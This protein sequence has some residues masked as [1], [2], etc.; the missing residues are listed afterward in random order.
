MVESDSKL[1]VSFLKHGLE[2]YDR[3]IYPILSRV[4]EFVRTF[5]S[6]SWSWVPKSAN[7][8]VDFVA[9]HQLSGMD[10]AVWV[11]RPPSSLVRILNKD[12]LTCPL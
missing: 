10:E 4:L 11:N 3:E 12:A 2:S 9:L 5:Q 7:E 6:R 8:A 1:A